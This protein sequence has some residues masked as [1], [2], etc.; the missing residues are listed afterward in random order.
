MDEDI[1]D[2]YWTGTNVKSFNFDDEDKVID[3]SIQSN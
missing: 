2:H 3:I 1:E